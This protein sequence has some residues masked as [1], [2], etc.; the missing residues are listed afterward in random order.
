MGMMESTMQEIF[1]NTLDC[2]LDNPIYNPLATEARIPWCLE[3]A[4]DLNLYLTWYFTY[5]FFFPIILSKSTY[6]VMLSIILYFKMDK[7][8]T[9]ELDIVTFLTTIFFVITTLHTY[10][11]VEIC[12]ISEGLFVNNTKYC[13]QKHFPFCFHSTV[14]IQNE[15]FCKKVLK[16]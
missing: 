14:C 11:N 6:P 16:N 9:V 13:K 3:A 12:L 4:F 7:T 1:N 2:A 8:S 10:P 5:S 15:N